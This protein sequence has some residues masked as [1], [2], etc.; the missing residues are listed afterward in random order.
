MRVAEALLASMPPGGSCSAG[1]AEWD[2]F[3]PGA[4]LIARADQALYAAKAQGRNRV[5]EWHAQ[6]G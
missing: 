5:L 6:L 1:V 3:E 2:G 4:S